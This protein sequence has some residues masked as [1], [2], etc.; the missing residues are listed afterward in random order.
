MKRLLVLAGVAILA[1]SAALAQQ[2]EYR[3]SKEG[4]VRAPPVP[5]S[6]SLP[7][8]GVVGNGADVE[9]FASPSVAFGVECV[10]EIRTCS[11][12]SLSGA[13]T[14]QSCEAEPGLACDTP[15][16]SS[17][18][19]EGT[20]A[21]YLQ[22]SV[23][24]NQTCTSQARE[25]FNG[26][27]SGTY[28]NAACEVAPQ[29]TTPAAIAFANQNGLNP[30]TTV[31]SNVAQ[32]LDVEGSIS[33]SISGPSAEYRVCGNAACSSGVGAWGSSGLVANGQY[34][35]L[36]MPSN[37]ALSGTAIANVS[38]GTFSTTWSLSTAS[39]VCNAIASP[40]P[41]GER[42]NGVAQRPNDTCEFTRPQVSAGQLVWMAPDVM[43]AEL[44]CRRLMGSNAR[45]A[46]YTV[47]GIANNSEQIGGSR[48]GTTFIS[49]SALSSRAETVRCTNAPTG[50]AA[51]EWLDG[52]QCRPNP[53]V[54]CMQ[55]ISDSDHIFED[56]HYDVGPGRCAT[57]RIRASNYYA[58]DG[59]TL[60]HFVATLQGVSNAVIE[61]ATP[62]SGTGNGYLLWRGSGPKTSLG[63]GHQATIYLNI[64]DPNY[65]AAGTLP[66]NIPGY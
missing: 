48:N 19:H 44:Y 58:Y 10:S 65:G 61:S 63:P 11:E 42:F 17:V 43:S 4:P 22:E 15:W 25:C 14:H 12:G 36:R 39:T 53:T 24:W 26:T 46:G 2:Y 6:C 30:S 45:L 33:V 32:V 49:T 27:L 47:G 5:T 56:K 51:G 8:G 37:A 57:A 13:F 1:S 9:A 60:L 21:A 38:I 41:S 34:I 54:S 40:T 55:I 50:C 66:A 18:A 62:Y 64:A 20:V 52:S 35:Q 31:M 59:A 29:D 28:T 23:A 16:G 7:W 3:Y